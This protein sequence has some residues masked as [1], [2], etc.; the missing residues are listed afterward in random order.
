MA[1]DN[2]RWVENEVKKRARYIPSLIVFLFELTLALCSTN[3]IYNTVSMVLIGNYFLPRSA[4]CS[5]R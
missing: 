3:A 5:D 2:V 1:I 4:V